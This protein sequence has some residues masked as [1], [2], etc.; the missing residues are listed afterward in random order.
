MRLILIGAGLAAAIS[1]AGLFAMTGALR[2][3]VS[4]DLTAEVELSDFPLPSGFGLEPQVVADFMIQELT[5]RSEND[6]AMRLALG[7]DGQKKLAE[8]VVPRLVSSAVVRE[9]I[10]KIKPLADVLAVGTFRASGHVV[11]RNAGAARGDVALTMPGAVLVEAETGAA[12]IT[13]TSTGLTA[14]KLGE[15]AAGEERVLHVWLDQ[16]AGA[17]IGK[18][19]R[20]GDGSG[21]RGRVW[22]FGHGAGWQGA[23]LQAMPA[24]RWVVLGVL[25]LVFLGS[26]LMVLMLALTRLRARRDRLG[27]SVA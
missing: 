18:Q 13:A 26:V 17:E 4:P 16:P 27:V 22:V 14:I 25:A 5:R 12:E 11:V 9:M 10:S 7:D 3:L 6:I 23:D 21:E 1:L 2:G 15:M 19:I 24:A 20:L 8:I